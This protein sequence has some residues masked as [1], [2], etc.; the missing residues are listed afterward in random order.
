MF[1][2]LPPTATSQPLSQPRPASNS[3]SLSTRILAAP[4]SVRDQHQSPLFGLM[5]GELRTIIFAYA[6]SACPDLSNPYSKHSYYYRPGFE[7]ASHIPG[8]TLLRTC[9]LIY[10]EAHLLAIS[11]NPHVFWMYRSPPKRHVFDVGTYFAKMTPEQRAVV[12]RMHVF[13]QTLWLS[14]LKEWKWR[15][16]WAMGLRI[17]HL[18]ITIRK[19]DWGIGSWHAAEQPLALDLSSWKE[20]VENVPVGENIEDI[21]KNAVLPS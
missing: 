20:W 10:L 1:I 7:H 21:E 17:S 2:Q 18:T 13:A 6:L 14:T 5:P 12:E 19:S 16:D 3:Q 4:T 11:Q 15:A 9:R 8:L